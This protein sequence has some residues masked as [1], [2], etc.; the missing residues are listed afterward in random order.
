MGM[1]NPKTKAECDE[2]ILRAQKRVN[3]AKLY[4]AQMKAQYG[5]SS[6]AASQARITVESAK[7]KL[8]E[9]KALRKT[10]K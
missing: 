4:L 10:L 6:S 3:E 7:G 1:G 9:L 8:A 2:A 5:S